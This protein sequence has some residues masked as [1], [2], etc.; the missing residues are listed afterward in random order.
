MRAV[1]ADAKGKG[2]G[3]NY[4]IQHS[5]GSGESRTRSPGRPTGSSRSTTTPNQPIFDTVVI[6]TD[7]IVLDRQLQGTVAQFEQTARLVKKIDG[8]SRDLDSPSRPAPASSS[9][10]SRSSGPDHLSELAAQRHRRFAVLV[11]EAHGSQSGATAARRSAP[12]SAAATAGNTD[13]GDDR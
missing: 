9:R 1:L 7:R 10:P 8:T 12:H 3:Q 4:L 5:C 2:P 11:D 13:R 6:V